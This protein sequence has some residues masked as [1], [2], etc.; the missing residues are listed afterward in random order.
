MKKL[1][2]FTL[3]IFSIFLSAQ[4]KL[5]MN[6]PMAVLRDVGSFENI[7]IAGPFKVYYS[8]GN[9]YQVAISAKSSAARDRIQVK[10]S[11]NILIIE[12]EKSY[13]NWIPG[14]DHFRVYVSSPS[15]KNITASGAVDFLVTDLLKSN[16]L[17]IQFT[18]ASDFLGKLDCQSLDLQ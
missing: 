15:V 1:L 9:S 14:D 3:L 11:G 2:L 17:K 5:I 4:E 8:I 18:G 12:L 6:D 13:R 7:E 16:D 10:K